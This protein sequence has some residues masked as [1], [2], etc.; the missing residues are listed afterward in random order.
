[1]RL[2]APAARNRPMTPLS[3]SLTCGLEDVFF[4]EMLPLS[5]REIALRRSDELFVRFFLLPM[6]N[7]TPTLIL[8]PPLPSETPT[9]VSKEGLAET[10]SSSPSSAS[11]I[12][13]ESLSAST[14]SS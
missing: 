6:L 5:L 10:S 1:M 12:Q 14:S 8:G 11:N 7:S 4:D 3:L 13:P 9:L 2:L